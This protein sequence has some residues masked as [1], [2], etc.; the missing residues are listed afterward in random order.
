VLDPGAFERTKV[1]LGR[2]TVCNRGRAVYRS[3]EAKICEVCYTRLVREE[4]ARAG[5]R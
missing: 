4:N 3:P 1:E 2:Y 5:V